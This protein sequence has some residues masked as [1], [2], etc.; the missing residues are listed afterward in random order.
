MA[1]FLV[2]KMFGSFRKIFKFVGDLFFKIFNKNKKEKIMYQYSGV[3][4]NEV[5]QDASESMADIPQ[6]RSLFVQKLTSDDPIK[7]QAVYDLKNI[8]EVFEHFK[9]EVSVEFDRPDGS[10]V[11]EDF[12]FG[13]V[14]DFS[15][16]NIT[17]KSNYLSDLQ[18]QQDQYQKI[19]KQL[20]T[21]K[22]MKNV[23]ENPE[24][25]TAFIETLQALLKEMEESN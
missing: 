14:G 3:G 6:N 16:K 24:L 2:K 7:P 1:S 15:T 20:K 12:R 11:N 10:S 23:I 19:I 4:G 18:I 13:N 21:N 17:S 22:V 9:P 8:D 5:K 25:K